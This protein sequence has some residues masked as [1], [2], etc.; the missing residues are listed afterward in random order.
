ML[1]G[2]NPSP[3]TPP[4]PDAS[5]RS[6]DTDAL[7]SRVSASSLSYF[8]DPF[9]SLFLPQSLLRSTTSTKRPP[10]INIGTHARTWAIDQLVEQF[11]NAGVGQVLSLGAGTDTR[12]WRLKEKFKEEE[13]RWNCK[14]WVEVDFE[15][16]TAQKA[17]IIAGKELLK[18]SLGGAMKI[19][20]GGTGLTSP[21]YSLLPSDLRSFASLSKILTSPPPSEPNSSP[22]LDPSIPTLL[23]AECVLVYLPPE[24][25]SEILRWFKKHFDSGS[26]VSYD[27]FG[28][29]DSFGKVMIRNL[30]TRNLALPGAS[31]TPTLESLSARLLQAGLSSASSLSIADIRKSIIPSQEIDR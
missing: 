4:S 31:A 19:E 26:V 21:S 20:Y 13:R 15:E 29:D 22:L 23:L 16:A 8:S 14:R 18:E 1:R 28:L 25:T 2:Q 27:P 5:V 7:L 9:A 17:R 6:T 3:S 30:A 11:L 24:T 10:L 12:F